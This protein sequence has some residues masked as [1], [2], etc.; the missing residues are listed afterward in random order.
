MFSL[1]NIPPHPKTYLNKCDIKK[2][3]IRIIREWANKRNR[4][5]FDLLDTLY[6]S[7]MSVI[8]SLKTNKN[9]KIIALNNEFK[10]KPV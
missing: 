6:L 2:V 5:L 10:K 4:Y 9:E 7:R 1:K 3:I 8:I